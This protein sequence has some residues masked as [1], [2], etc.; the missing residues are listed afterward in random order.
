MSLNVMNE[1]IKI[2]KKSIYQYFRLIL[3]EKYDKKI[4]EGYVNTY[5]EIRYYDINESKLYR[6]LKKDVLEGMNEEKEKL[7]LQYPEKEE[8]IKNIRQFFNY[9]I[10]LD[11]L[12]LNKDINRVIKYLNNARNKILGKKGFNEDIYDIIKANIIKKEEF[13]KKFESKDFYIKISR[14]T[15]TVDIYRINLKY[16]IKFPIL[17][18]A[19][20]INKAFNTGTT[21]EDRLF[22]EYY[23]AT[24]HIIQDI[25]K[26][27]FKKQY[28]VELVETLFAKSQKIETLLNIINN[29]GIQDKLSLKIRYNTFLNNKEKT[30]GLIKKGFKIAIII[31]NNVELDLA[32]VEKLGIFTYVLINKEC[33][34]YNRLNNNK[35]TK[36][37]L[38]Q[39]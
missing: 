11:N 27:N 31:D 29:P 39:I 12:N 6:K 18:S 9:I 17:Y 34:H 20:A 15:E 5:I 25:I 19:L 1:Y 37:K 2:T 26:G 16:D 33:K 13:L 24:V 14:Y 21:N 7:I 38:I 10:Y 22:V 28:I 8:N 4:C 23:L 30:Y 32:D 36:Q 35:F 3:E